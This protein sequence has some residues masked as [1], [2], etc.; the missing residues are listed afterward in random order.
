MD[1]C[2]PNHPDCVSGVT[3]TNCDDGFNPHLIVACNLVVFSDTPID[4]G[5]IVSIDENYYNLGS[6]IT[7]FPNPSE[8]QMELSFHGKASFGK[9]EVSLMNITG[10]VMNE[11]VWYGETKTLNYADLSK[12]VY[13]LQ[14]EVADKLEVKKI[15]IQ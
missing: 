5:Y 13:F 12:G 7:L 1:Y 15:V 11:F 9:A 14:I 4:N 6:Y 10:T 3:C 2:H 8:G